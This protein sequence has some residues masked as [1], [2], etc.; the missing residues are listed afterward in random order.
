MFKKLFQPFYPPEVDPSYETRGLSLTQFQGQV[1]LPLSVPGCPDFLFENESE[2]ELRIKFKSM[3]V[4]EVLPSRV[5]R[6][7]GGM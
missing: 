3:Q 6:K 7:L 5:I 1:S 4:P 2:D